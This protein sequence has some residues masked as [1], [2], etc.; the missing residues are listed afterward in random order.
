MRN[1]SIVAAEPEMLAADPF[2][3]EIDGAAMLADGITLMST[4]GSA[5]VRWHDVITVLTERQYCPLMPAVLKVL[6]KVPMSV[7]IGHSVNGDMLLRYIL[8]A[9]AVWS[10]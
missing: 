6:G 9:L 5:S 1:L 10:D 7:A 8:T 4:H 3:R 2:L